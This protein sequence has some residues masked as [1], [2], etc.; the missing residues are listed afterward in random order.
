VT[1]RQAGRR[2]AEGSV[3]GQS[4]ALCILYSIQNRFRCHPASNPMCKVGFGRK[5]NRQVYEANK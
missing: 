3:T 2:R 5:E 1:R 4:K